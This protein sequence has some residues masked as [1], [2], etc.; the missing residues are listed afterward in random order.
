MVL[1]D[2]ALEIENIPQGIEDYE[3][4]LEVQKQ[5]YSDHDRELAEIYYKVGIAHQYNNSF[6]IGRDNMKKAIEIL[7]N[8]IKVLEATLTQENGNENEKG[9]G[10]GKSKEDETNELEGSQNH[11]QKEI[12]ELKELIERINEKVLL[13]YFILFYLFYFIFL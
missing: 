1:G 2:L 7:E 3:R 4:S 8:R 9:K 12:E 11:T 13:F 5:I 6:D 10:K